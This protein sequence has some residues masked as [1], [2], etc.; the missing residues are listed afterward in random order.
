MKN[1]TKGLV[2]VAIMLGVIPILPLIGDAVGYHSGEEKYGTD[3]NLESVEAISNN[4]RDALDDVRVYDEVNGR[5][6][7]IKIEDFLM[8]AV[9]GSVSPE[10]EDELLQA[11]AVLM[12][13]YIIG[14]R[15]SDADNSGLPENADIGR[16]STK[17][18]RLISEEEAKMLYGDMAIIYIKK[19][20][21]A[22]R[23][24]LG[25]YL[26]YGGKPIAVAYCYSS[27]GQTES[28]LNVMGE[29]LPYLKSVECGYDRECKSE[30]VFTADELFAMLSTGDKPLTI[31]G[32]EEQWLEIT[33]TTETGYVLEVTVDESE[34]ISGVELA[35]LLG[36]PSA[37]FT[38][39]YSKELN[40]FIFN[41]YGFGHLMGISQYG[42]NEMA[43][44]GAKHKEILLYF[45]PGSTLEK[46]N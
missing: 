6:E 28:S 3:E 45:F 39:N 26:S 37:K 24:C 18:L 4:Y 12:Y 23:A 36:L 27:G 30:A 14:K 16:D 21:A 8:Q 40:R 25:E 7:A 33:K 1:F 34:T 19:V 15:D 35:A 9:L 46:V 2:L 13:T 41:I 29:D 42:G 22:V 5:V 10:A 17:Y 32:S 43:K 31:L 11:Q 38:L 20:K 44:K